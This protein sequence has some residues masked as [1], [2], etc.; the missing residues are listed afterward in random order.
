MPSTFYV[1]CSK[2]TQYYSEQIDAAAKEAEES[3]KE[4]VGA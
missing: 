1:I 2:F 3:E 4:E